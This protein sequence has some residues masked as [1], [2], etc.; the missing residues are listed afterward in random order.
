M[1]SEVLEYQC[2]TTKGTTTSGEGQLVSPSSTTECERC[3][4][5]PEDKS[6]FG[7]LSIEKFEYNYIGTHG[8]SGVLGLD[9]FKHHSSLFFNGR[10]LW[11]GRGGELVSEL[12]SD[13]E[14]E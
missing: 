7:C 1:K 4:F 13:D 10:I 12:L 5:K 2:W 8:S 3:K 11:K 9:H 14:W 6:S